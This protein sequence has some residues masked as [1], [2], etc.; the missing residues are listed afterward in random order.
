MKHQLKIHNTVINKKIED[1]V[2]VV[3]AADRE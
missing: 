3:E 2:V 1:I